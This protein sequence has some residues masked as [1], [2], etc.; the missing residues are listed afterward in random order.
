MLKLGFDTEK[1]FTYSKSALL[2]LAVMGAFLVYFFSISEFSET[3][4][5]SMHIV[6]LIVAILAMVVS[7]SF[8]VPCITMSSFVIIISYIIINSLRYV[9]GEDYMFS[10]G[11]N[12]WCMCL[13]PDLLLA[14]VCFHHNKPYK[15]WSWFYI[16]ILLQTALIERLQTHNIDADSYYF[17]KHI[18]VFNY[19]AL[20]IAVFCILS[21]FIHQVI[22]G[23]ILSATNL[24]VSIMIFMSV[25]LSDNLYAFCLF[26]L[27]A[28]L[29]NLLSVSYYAYYTLYR[30]EELEIANVKAFTLDAEKK[31]PLKYSV[32]LMYIDEY[33]RLTKRFGTA[34]IRV[35]KKM[36]LERIHKVKPSALV[37]N[38]K[39]DALIIV[40]KN[41]NAAEGFNIAE[42]I[43]RTIA[44]S[45]FIF[46]ENNR[47]QLTVSQCVSEFRRSDA[48][49]MGVLN[50]AEENLKKACKF[51]RNITVKA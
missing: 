41:T 45:I 10:S 49:A 25:L 43:R 11:Y 23:H 38:Y 2:P 9:Y 27:A 3:A 12:I 1:V 6:F 26:F 17:Y 51:T 35:L 15:Y 19:P 47:V 40:F 30:D 18:G 31:Y 5:H 16:F 36:F 4:Y 48:G 13:F 44:K 32:V 22:C 46:N 39:D 8:K 28:A 24:G 20:Y 33:N 37:Y 14:Y 21:L 34:K 7:A 29:I 42:E 50:R